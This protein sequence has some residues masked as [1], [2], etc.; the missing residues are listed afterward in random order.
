MP[1]GLIVIPKHDR[2]RAACW[3]LL[4]LALGLGVSGCGPGTA[5]AAVRGKELFETCVPCH[6]ES[7]QGNAQ[8]G[9]PNIGGMPA[10]YIEAQLRMFRGGERGLNFY[11]TEGMR[12]RPMSLS[13]DSDQDVQLVARYVASLPKTQHAPTIKGDVEA[14]DHQF[15]A[16]CAACHGQN[17]QGNQAIKAP[18]LAGVDDWYLAR[19]LNKFKDGVRGTSPKDVQG[20]MMAPMAKTLANEAAVRNVVAYIATL[21]P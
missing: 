7:G 2:L 10:W 14:G 18:R 19:Q 16:I 1:L 6:G 17:A 12:M 5:N 8:L 4:I 9:A 21:K 20:R 11:D 13:L 3:V 15:H